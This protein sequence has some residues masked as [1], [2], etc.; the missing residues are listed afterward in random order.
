MALGEDTVQAAEIARED[1]DTLQSVLEQASADLEAAY[2]SLDSG[3]DALEQTRETIEAGFTTLANNFEEGADVLE[4]ARGEAEGAVEGLDEVLSEA[5]SS[6]EEAFQ[7]VQDDAESSAAEIETTLEAL[8]ERY[9]EFVAEA[10]QL[11]QSVTDGRTNLVQAK[12]TAVQ[13]VSNLDELMMSGRT[14]VETAR[15]T[16][17]TALHNHADTISGT[18]QP[19]LQSQFAD[20]SATVRD[21]HVPGLLAGFEDI[22]NEAAE[23]HEVLDDCVRDYAESLTNHAT[24]TARDFSERFQSETQ[25]VAGKIFGDIRAG[26]DERAQQTASNRQRLMD[27]K[28]K[29]EESQTT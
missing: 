22:K 5:N 13:S 25:S 12:E 20:I 3:F 10:G 17:E 28:T 7:L 9:S 27:S 26:L 2:A 4:S 1:L 6:L 23:V 16:A 8:Q 18:H 19:A 29:W 24:Q 11:I 15:T 14:Q 21:H